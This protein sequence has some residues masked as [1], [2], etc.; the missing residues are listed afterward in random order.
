[1]TKKLKN[2]KKIPHQNILLQ[3]MNY[4]FGNFESEGSWPENL[5]KGL[6]VESKSFKI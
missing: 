1:M 2:L 6:K 3:I 4:Q 5:W